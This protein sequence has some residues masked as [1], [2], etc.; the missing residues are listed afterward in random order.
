MTARPP[1]CCL[2]WLAAALLALT[3]FGLLLDVPL[4]AGE[5]RL[6]RMAELVGLLVLSAAVYFAAVR[7]VLRY[8]WPRT[9]TW[10]VLGVAMALRAL[11]LTAP[12]ILS[13]DIY[14]YV[15][16]GRVQAAGIN[17]YR[18]IPADP[19]LAALR[20]SNIYP[21]ISRA[22]YARTIYPPVAELLFAAAGRVSHSVTGMRLFMLGFE[23]IGIICMLRL[24]ALA[25]LPGERILIYAWNPLAFWSFANDGHVDAI[26][27]GLLGLAL[28]LRAR[29]KDGWAGAA[30]AGA[31]LT[32]LFP[33]VVAPAF[34]R[35]GR[36]WRPALAGLVVIGCGYALYAGAGRHVLGFLPSYGPEEG[37]DSGQ[38]IW[39]LAGL[40]Q[41][42]PLP[43]AAPAVYAAGIALIFLGLVI[44][45]LRQRAFENDVRLLCRDTGLLAATAMAAISPHYHW[46]FAW[47]ALPAVVAPSRALLWL[48]TA[49]LLLIEEPVP[50]DRFFWPSLVYVPAILLLLADLRHRIAIRHRRGPETG[51]TSCP[52]Q[53]P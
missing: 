52:L 24:L 25:G 8:A 1:L 21:L 45:I 31:V 53:L 40:T 16:D 19:A 14:R 10:L 47:L 2:A 18:Y 32:K 20:D 26:V 22:D 6:V 39:L 42:V 3:V 44:V 38:G 49:P 11:L 9:T 12:P 15:W 23:A 27:V 41:V 33:L 51:D 29:H 5:V 17:P 13:T 36:F 4:T 50:G 34:L 30:L 7:L 37:I 43:A 28:L 48:A 46:Y 35:G